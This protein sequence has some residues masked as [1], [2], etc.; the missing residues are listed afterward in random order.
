[1]GADKLP[2]YFVGNLGTDGPDVC[3]AGEQECQSR[4]HHQDGR[5][6]RECS[7]VTAGQPG[8]EGDC[9]AMVVSRTRS[10]GRH[11][12]QPDRAGDLARGIGSPDA[13]PVVKGACRHCHGTNDS[14]GPTRE[15]QR[16]LSRCLPE[17]SL[18]PQDV[19][20]AV[21]PPCPFQGSALSRCKD[22]FSSRL[23]HV[24]ARWCTEFLEM[25]PEERLCGRR[26]E[27]AG[28]WISGRSGCQ[29]AFSSRF[30]R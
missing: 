11:R 9:W 23:R 19:T 8:A 12:S 10:D 28:S 27:V 21:P 6:N 15:G 25:R 16:A 13:S 2:P 29:I 24:F 1:M 4:T 26:P 18:P 5:R 30:G 22:P 7:V 14:P 3:R 20:A 17:M